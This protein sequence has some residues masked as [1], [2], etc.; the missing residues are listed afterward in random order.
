MNPRDWSIEEW[1]ILLCIVLATGFV[2]V[3]VW[4]YLS[5]PEHRET[6]LMGI[7]VGALTSVLLPG[8]R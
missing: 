1:L 4:L 6:L 8:G 3:L 2:C 5:C 7:L